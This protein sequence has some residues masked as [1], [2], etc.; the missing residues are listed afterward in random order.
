MSAGYDDDRRGDRYDDDRPDDRYDDRDRPARGTAAA[1]RAAVPGLF[2]ILN[3]LVGIIACVAVAGITL[4]D[5]MVWAEL[6]RKGAADQPDPQQK[7]KMEDMAQQMED[8]IKADPNG[9]ATRTV[10]QYGG[11]IATNALAVF[12]GT[13]MRSG[14]GWGWGVAGSAVSLLPV[15]TGCCCTGI[16]LGIWGL[17]VL[18]NP[19]VKAAFAARRRPTDR[20]NDDYR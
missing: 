1:G 18:L 5:P 17:V 20:Y 7:Q 16:P 19:D 6:V 11:L 10:L 4:A 2:L 3:G 9:V 8:A 12:G 15:A 13:R 14:R